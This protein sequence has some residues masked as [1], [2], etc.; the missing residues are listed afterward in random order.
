MGSSKPDLLVEAGSEPPQAAYQELW[1]VLKAFN[2]KAIGHCENHP[3]A[4]L[5]RDPETRAVVGGVWGR[6]VWDSF[7]VD[8][9]VAPED[10][11]GAGLGGD[12]MAQV[13]AE[14][15]SRGCLNIWLDT[16]AFQARPFYERLG[17][18]VFG[19]IDGPKPMFPRYFMIKDL[20]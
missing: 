9:L 14:A 11:R 3:F 19:Q 1:E 12:L 5:L 8:M 4:V 7:Y 6:S 2:V 15:R 10:Q 13:E 18:R 20:A 16:F 17:F